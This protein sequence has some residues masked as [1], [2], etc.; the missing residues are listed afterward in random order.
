M[1]TLSLVVPVL[2][3]EK[4]LDGVIDRLLA[5]PDVTE[6]I[7]VNDG[8]SDRTADVLRARLDRGEPRL[9]VVTHERN[10]GKG[11][12]IRSAIA[13]ATSDFLMIQDADAEYDPADMVAIFHRLAA[14]EAPVVYGSRFLRWNPTLY[15]MY[16]IGNKVLTLVANLLGGGHLTDA[17]T[18]YKGMSVERWRRLGLTSSGF[19]IEAEISIKCLLLGWK[20]LEVPIHYKPRSFA[21]GKKIRGRDA[22]KGVATMLKYFVFRPS[23]DGQ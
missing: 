19:E 9:R 23:A 17:Y 2:N 20:I 8:S 6:L 15:R 11:A 18:C 12:A 21:E 5:F 7:V 16:L 3:E 4:T 13:A 1:A 22:V 10:Q 14:G